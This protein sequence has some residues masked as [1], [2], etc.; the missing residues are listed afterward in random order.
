MNTDTANKPGL[1]V[2]AQQIAEHLSGWTAEAHDSGWLAYLVHL[3]GPRLTLRTDRERVTVHGAWPVDSNRQQYCP[4]GK[5]AEITCATARRPEA[6]AKDI[7]RRLFPVYL[8]LWEEQD[9]RRRDAEKRDRE[10]EGVVRRLEEILG[11]DPADHNRNG[12]NDAMHLDFNSFRVTV[13]RYG[14]YKVEVQTED[15]ERVVRLAEL[16][17][18]LRPDD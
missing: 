8:P 14:S 7:E 1:I 5:R 4:Y 3:A 16:A 13:Y 17:K 12:R 2:L 15:P 18:V 9:Q 6:I 10:A 11:L